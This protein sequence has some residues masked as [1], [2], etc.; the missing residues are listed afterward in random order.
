MAV[1]QGGT[2]AQ[3]ASGGLQNLGGLDNVAGVG[4]GGENLV[5]QSKTL[6]SGAYRA[7]LKGLKPTTQYHISIASDGNDIEPGAVPNNILDGVS[8]VRVLNG[9]RLTGA[10]APVG[11]NDLATKAYVDSQTTCLLYTSPS[12]RDRTR[13]RMPSSA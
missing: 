7:E 12:P 9:A 6:V 3:T 4:I 11:D 8:G 2:G 1:S 10:S 5:F 13:S